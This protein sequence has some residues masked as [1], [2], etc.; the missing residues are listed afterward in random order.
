MYSLTKWWTSQVGLI[1]S[2]CCCSCCM[3]NGNTGNVCLKMK[4]QDAR[5]R[6][7]KETEVNWSWCNLSWLFPRNDV[8]LWLKLLSPMLGTLLRICT[9]RRQAVWQWLLWVRGTTWFVFFFFPLLA[10]KCT[11]FEHDYKQLLI[12]KSLQSWNKSWGQ[13]IVLNNSCWS[14]W[15]ERS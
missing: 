11:L 3:G 12:L 15:T 4:A 2:Q 9:P 6:G 7:E 8:N 5:V 1:S 10:A 13:L 14:Y